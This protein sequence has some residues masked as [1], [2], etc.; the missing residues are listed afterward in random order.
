MEKIKGIWFLI[1]FNYKAAEEIS[2]IIYD[3]FCTIGVAY[4]FEGH[5]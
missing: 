3:K 4:I 1:I 5:I 2:T